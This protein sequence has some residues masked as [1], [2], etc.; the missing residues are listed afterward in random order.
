MLPIGERSTICDDLT[1]GCSR[2]TAT[3]DKTGC[4][5]QFKQPQACIASSDRLLSRPAF[6]RTRH[7]L[8]PFF[9]SKGMVLFAG[10]DCTCDSSPKSGDPVKTL[11]GLNNYECTFKIMN[12]LPKV[13]LSPED[14]FTL[15]MRQQQ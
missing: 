14:P 11:M 10:K 8:R 2:C 6:F 15:Q 7:H 13:K 4:V 1:F 5:C 12:E 3:E 9:T